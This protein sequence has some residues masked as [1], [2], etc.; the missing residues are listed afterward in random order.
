MIKAERGKMDEVKTAVNGLKSSLDKLANDTYSISKLSKFKDDF[1]NIKFDNWT[2]EVQSIL[3]DTITDTTSKLDV[4]LNSISYGNFTK[5]R[6][7]TNLILETIGYYETA[8]SK[9]YECERLI[10][11]PANADKEQYL[12]DLKQSR[13]DYSR[14]LFG[15]IDTINEYLTR[16]STYDFEGFG[17]SVGDSSS[18]TSG[19]IA[20][21][22]EEKAEPPKEQQTEYVTL[23]DGTKMPVK[24]VPRPSNWG[25][26][27]GQYQAIYSDPNTSI[28]RVDNKDLHGY[29]FV[30]VSYEPIISNNPKDPFMLVNGKAVHVSGFQEVY[31]YGVVSDVAV[32]GDASAATGY[33]VSGG[34]K[35]ANTVI[36]EYC[37]DGAFG[38]KPTYY[39]HEYV[40]A[41]YTT[42]AQTGEISESS[43]SRFVSDNQV[44]LIEPNK[45]SEGMFRDAKGIT[46]SSWSCTT[47]G[48]VKASDS[49]RVSGKY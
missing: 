23:Q 30:T 4:I 28:Y 10:N 27:M 33:I 18:L 37:V 16:Y 36:Y 17:S 22:P 42:S 40:Y 35:A 44:S 31:T 11:D 15:Y 2:D 24:K 29:Y 25:E 34:Y 19:D 39:T 5:I 49:S 3:S 32:G 45:T 9:F 38:G 7:N 1:N 41:K 14:Q 6:A 26:N 21:L 12:K 48:L 43:I 8:N 46:Y 13:S 47:A 20:E